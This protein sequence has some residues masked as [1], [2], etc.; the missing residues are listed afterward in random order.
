MTEPS[1][2][3][4]AK[5]R[6]QAANALPASQW[7]GERRP[8]PPPALIKGVFPQT[9]VAMLG[10]QSGAG[11]TFHAINIG[12]HLIPDCNKQFYIDEYRIKRHGGVLYIV[13]EGKPAFPSRGDRS[14]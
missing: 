5:A 8:P 2:F 12:V 10:G 4:E 1:P 13:L 7:M 9:G 11:K 14:L 6:Q 3:A